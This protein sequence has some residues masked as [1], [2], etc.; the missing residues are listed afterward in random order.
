MMRQH[1][2]RNRL[3]GPSPIYVEILDFILT[4]VGVFVATLNDLKTQTLIIQVFPRSVNA[5]LRRGIMTKLLPVQ[6]L[7]LK[8]IRV[9]KAFQ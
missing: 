7:F 3:R 8:C 4:E 6:Q 5:L 9:P 1:K 2:A